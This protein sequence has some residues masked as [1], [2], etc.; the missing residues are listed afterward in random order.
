MKKK[1]GLPFLWKGIRER[2]ALFSVILPVVA[3]LL[4]APG[5]MA[6]ETGGSGILLKKVTYQANRSS[7]SNVLRDIR[8]KA[9]VRFTYNREVIGQQQPVTV[10]VVDVTLDALLKQV[11]Q[12][13]GLVFREEMGGIVIYEE[14]KTTHVREPQG[15]RPELNVIVRGKITDPAGQA[16]SGV[17]IR[18]EESKAMSVTEAD[19]LFLLTVKENEAIHFTRLGMK[20]LHYKAK[21]GAHD[22]IVLKMDTLVREIG[23]VVVNGY[24]KIDPRLSTGA[25][26]K[27]SAAEVLQPGVPT[28]DKMLQGKVPGLM[29]INNSGSVNSAPTMRIRGTSTLI[30]NASPLWVIDGMIRPDPVDISAGLL[31]NLISDASKANYQIMGNAISGLNPYDIESLT[32]LRDAAATAIYGTSAAN[33]VIVI[34][35]KRGKDGPIRINYNSNYAFQQRP[36]YNQLKLMNSQERV[37]LSRQFQEDKTLFAPNGAGL[38]EYDTYEGLTQALNARMI[39][40]ATYQE[41]VA[42]L[43]TQNTDWFRE[44]FR[45]QFSMQHSLSVSGGQGRTQY[46]ASINFGDNKGAAEKD[47]N[48]NYGASLSLRSLIGKRM[49]MDIRLQ[50]NLTRAS[51]YFGSVN[52]L[53]YALQTTRTLGPDVYYARSTS[54]LYGSSLAAFPPLRFNMRNEL[55]HTG[56]NSEVRSSSV[57]LNLD[58]RLAKGLTFRN[59]SS[60]ITDVSN[61]FSYSDEYSH[62]IAKKR[63]WDLR[64][65]ELA[66]AYIA[67]IGQTINDRILG[68]GG[69][70]YMSSSNSTVLALRNS[71]DY[72]AGLFGDRDQFSFTLGNEVR[73]QVRSRNATA[74]PGYFPERGKIFSPSDR[75]KIEASSASLDE[76]KNNSVS[77]YANAA[78]SLMNRYVVSA[79]IRTDGS[80]RF[81]QYANSRFLPNYSISGRWNIAS[82]SWFPAG[83]LV[84]DWQM[85]A[86]FGTQGNVVSAV[87]PELIATYRNAT[88]NKG[89][90]PVMR[91]KTLPYP[92]LRWEKTYQFNIGTN[93]SMFDNRFRASLDYYS[94][95]SVDVLDMVAI[96][97]EYGMDAMYRNGSELFNKG[98]ELTIGM[99][100]VRNTNTTVSLNIM[101]SR[102]M[103]RVSDK[104]TSIKY[105]DF[106]T[107]NGHLPGKAISGFYSYI[108]KGLNHETGYPEFDKLGRADKTTNLEEFLVYSGQMQPTA[109]FNL[110]PVVRYKAFSMSA[111]LYLSLGSSKRLNSPFSQVGTYNYV[112]AG[113]TNVSREYLNRWRKPGDELYTHI[114]KAVDNVIPSQYLVVPYVSTD[115]NTIGNASAIL[116]SPYQAYNQSDVRTVKNDYLRC[117]N[118]NIGYTF[119]PTM[120]KGTG[121]R[122]LNASFNVNNVFTIA[123][124]ELKGQDPEIDGVGA[125]ALPL[126]RQFAWSISATF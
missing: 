79:T 53:D 58:Y 49:T 63:T 35:T 7:L 115:R 93:L 28:I 126:T 119:P 90:V 25:V 48:Q 38:V 84:G 94:K 27:L 1:S 23:E 50:S 24:Q 19:G 36:G 117:N 106:L 55:A 109:T 3:L 34:T 111:G 5:V 92:D 45:N 29:I 21:P 44:L 116:V 17:S 101:S 97:F 124:P 88:G 105:Q 59:N 64:D 6:Q 8:K 39:D 74:N 112:P 14:K 57:N 30:G 43:E 107:G 72:S 70:A 60:F 78:Y 9:Q 87:G 86:S 95:R 103:N 67:S 104:V 61:G 65:T 56:N 33:G 15:Q 18:S 11:L 2:C 82:E 13:T 89:A 54:T 120:L 31:N 91:I 98:L 46:Y 66:L 10:K 47:G 110:Q 69:M 12:N 62:D 73:S 4:A 122:G 96:P 99:D 100:V 80:N 102:N 52:P 41:R 37:T 113:F 22:L 121:I 77:V 71:L 16:L 68:T 40:E 123:N 42:Q 125:T 114:P 83:R 108:F 32:F 81:G 85:R 26:F 76:S 20:P 118:I 51:G 75:S